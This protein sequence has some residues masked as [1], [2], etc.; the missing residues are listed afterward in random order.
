[1]LSGDVGHALLEAALVLVPMILSLTVHEFAHAAMARSLGDDT[2]ERLG[3]LNLN[4]LS[5]IDPVGTLV[6]PLILMTSGA[7]F[8]FGWA[9]PV[10]FNP[11]RFR[12][13]VNIRTGATLVAAA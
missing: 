8:S 5:H 1:M 12:R 4:P 2:A 7:P 13:D 10:P 11:A 6:L 9:K 3:R